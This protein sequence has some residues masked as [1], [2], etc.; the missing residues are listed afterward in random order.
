VEIGNQMEQKALS[1]EWDKFCHRGSIAVA[2]QRESVRR[3]L[4]QDGV[5]RGYYSGLALNPE[6]SPAHPMYPSHDHTT[7]PRDHDKMVVDVRIVNDMK[8]ILTEKEFWQ[9]VGHLY[10]VGVEKGKITSERIMEGWSPE[11]SY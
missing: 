5:V 8:T 9:M 11:R 2:K 7:F 6:L 4:G 10:A 3:C 1:I